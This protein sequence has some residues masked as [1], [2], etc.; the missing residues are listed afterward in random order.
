[1]RIFGTYLE[2]TLLKTCRPCGGHGPE[3]AKIQSEIASTPSYLHKLERGKTKAKKL[4]EKRLQG[5]T[6]LKEPRSRRRAR[7]KNPI[8][9]S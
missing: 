1:M 6:Q 3:K 5:S 4:K 8:K 2:E 7:K 9:T